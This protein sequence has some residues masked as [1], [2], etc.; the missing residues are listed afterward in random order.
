MSDE[1]L[2]DIEVPADLFV[3]D[4]MQ[5]IEEAKAL[6]ARVISDDDPKEIVKD[7]AFR[8]RSPRYMRLVAS[9]AARIVIDLAL[10]DE[11]APP[12]AAVYGARLGNFL[13]YTRVCMGLAQL[14]N[15]NPGAKAPNADGRPTS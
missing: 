4:E 10:D 15:D 13:H 14:L 11:T 1:E 7:L 9:T 8:T 6:A 2:D 5:A 12:I 3:L